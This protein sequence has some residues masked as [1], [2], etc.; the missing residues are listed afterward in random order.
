M[1]N[2]DQALQD[3]HRDRDRLLD[4]VSE[5]A[6][7]CAGLAETKDG[8][9]E[10][11][12]DL[13]KQI[14]ALRAAAHASELEHE[15]RVSEL[16]ARL[17]DAERTHAAHVQDATDAADVAAKRVAD[18]QR[19]VTGAEGAVT[20]LRGQLNDGAAEIVRLQ[21]ALSE[22]SAARTA[23]EGKNATLE[24]QKKLDDD[25]IKSLKIKSL[26]LDRSVAAIAAENELAGRDVLSLKKRLV[27]LGASEARVADD[28]GSVRK[29][30][31]DAAAATAAG[32]VLAQQLQ[33]Q[34]T[35]GKKRNLPRRRVLTLV[36]PLLQ[37]RQD[38]D[39]IASL[40]KQMSDLTVDKA[41]ADKEVCSLRGTVQQL[42]EDGAGVVRRMQD[43]EAAAAA[44]I[45]ALQSQV[46]AL[47]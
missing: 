19:S 37:V 40:R 2:K 13:L 15:R 6:S 44:T 32:E 5:G 4:E 31:A 8:L 46:R 30:Y 24:A 45:A 12:Q 27:E 43:A 14:D 22:A 33:A 39:E 17:L 36:R 42:V 3:I 7:R 21:R 35:R 16:E 11:V 10:H 9:L 26:D 28:L 18:L 47:R 41:A 34:V 29:Q 38:A 25:Q 1:A 20:A 23:A